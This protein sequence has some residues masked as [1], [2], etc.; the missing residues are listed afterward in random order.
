MEEQLRKEIKKWMVKLEKAVDQTKA[1]DRKGFD[2][3]TNIRAYQSD[4]LHFY[5]KDD[6]V[7]SF[8]ALIWAW[9]YCEIGREMGILS[10]K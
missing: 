7:R 3:L 6:L 4:S 9:A 10:G 2:F 1:I 8:E 5:H